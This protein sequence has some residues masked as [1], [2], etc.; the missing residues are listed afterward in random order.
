MT[1]SALAGS[2]CED[3]P[4]AVVVEYLRARMIDVSRPVDEVAFT[5]AAE[6][7]E[8]WTRLVFVGDG[9]DYAPPSDPQS[10]CKRSLSF[11]T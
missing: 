9:D 4:P 3:Q 2:R 10:F 11:V 6:V 1:L 8:V 7:P 5:Q